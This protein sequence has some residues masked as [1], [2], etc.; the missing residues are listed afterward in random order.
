[1]LCACGVTLDCVFSSRAS[2]RD[3][4]LIE[5]PG[6][7]TKNLKISEMINKVVY[8]NEEINLLDDGTCQYIAS[9]VAGSV[10]FQVQILVEDAKVCL[11]VFL[12]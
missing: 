2:N 8:T 4:E 3:S 6:F 11:H 10:K 7:L 1:V 5:N 9:A 12:K